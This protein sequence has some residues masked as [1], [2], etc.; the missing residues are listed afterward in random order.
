MRRSL[1]T[2]LVVVVGLLL[3]ADFAIV[4]PSVGAIAGAL[5]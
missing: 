4:N 3:L 1:P 2:T 5:L